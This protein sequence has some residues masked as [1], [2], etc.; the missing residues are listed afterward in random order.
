MRFLFAL[1]LL[2]QTMSVMAVDFSELSNNKPVSTVYPATFK[3][4]VDVALFLNTE[5]V[6][7]RPVFLRVS[8][9]IGSDTLND[10]IQVDGNHNGVIKQLFLD[11]DEHLTVNI[12]LNNGDIET[13]EG[14]EGSLRVVRNPDFQ[15]TEDL[16]KSTFLSGVWKS[17]Q[18][19]LFRIPIKD[20][21]PQYFRLKIDFN[22]N[23]EFDKLYFELK[24]ISPLDGIVMLNK[25]IFV[26]EN[27]AI[28]LRTRSYAMDIKEIDMSHPGT[29]Y[30]QVMNDMAVDRLNGIDKISYE[31]VQE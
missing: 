22:K 21:I 2:L 6:Y 29:Y 12:R 26:N 13:I 30:F 19:P 3:C 8:Y 9:I 20:S 15:P 1:S 23:Y 5:G 25:E 28:E 17:E 27:P 18:T 4:Y 11:E 10:N 31:I 16:G 14:L 24:V 7:E